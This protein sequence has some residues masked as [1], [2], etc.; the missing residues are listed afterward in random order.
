MLDYLIAYE[1]G[2]NSTHSDPFVWEN[3]LYIDKTLNIAHKN[4][5][6]RIKTTFNLTLFIH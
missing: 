5:I 1:G 2:I 6:E 3:A 4:Q